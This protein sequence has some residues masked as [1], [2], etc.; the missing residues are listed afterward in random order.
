MKTYVQELRIIA[1]V[2]TFYA[3]KVITND[4]EKKPTHN[5]EKNTLKISYGLFMSQTAT[6]NNTLIMMSLIHLFQ[7]GV[8]ELIVLY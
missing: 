6:Q 8:V 3:L 5:G 1:L 7:A 2:L 4:W